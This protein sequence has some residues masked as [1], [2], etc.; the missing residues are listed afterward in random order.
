M[1]F[2]FIFLALVVI[3]PSIAI[4]STSTC[5]IIVYGKLSTNQEIETEIYRK[6]E[7]NLTQNE[8]INLLKTSHSEL[9]DCVLKYEGRIEQVE[10][11]FKVEDLQAQTSLWVGKFCH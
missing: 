10:M 9:L 6:S 2:L 4:S 7:A 5:D 11:D 1:K 8:C 3:T